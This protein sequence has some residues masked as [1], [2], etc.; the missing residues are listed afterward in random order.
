MQ[1]SQ[2]IYK[3]SNKSMKT[4]DRNYSLKEYVWVVKLSF[5]YV[6]EVYLCLASHYMKWDWISGSAPP[7]VAICNLCSSLFWPLFLPQSFF[8]S[9]L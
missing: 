1:F 8:L 6:Q 2:M 4:F 9:S 7:T 3:M 5:M